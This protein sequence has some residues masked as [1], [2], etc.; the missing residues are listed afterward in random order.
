MVQQVEM[1]RG[2][3]VVQETHLDS[4]FSASCQIM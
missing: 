1:D 3:N 4:F 2:G